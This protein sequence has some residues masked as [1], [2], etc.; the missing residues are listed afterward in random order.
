[1]GETPTL[2]LCDCT[3]TMDVDRD[4][5]QRGCGLSCSK[6][7]TFLCGDQAAAAAN[8]LQS[9][10]VLIACGQEI[11]AFEDLAQDLDALHNLSFV[12]IRDR[13]GWSDDRATA[14]KMAAL[15]ADARL[16]AP[17]L[18]GSTSSPMACAWST[19]PSPSRCRPLRAW[20]RTWP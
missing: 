12:D 1:M 2:L 6:V 7:H 5:I 13:A 4:A 3:G 20:R 9:G 11:A 16:P 17:R 15:V 19:G 10:P 18:Q 14:P 8:A